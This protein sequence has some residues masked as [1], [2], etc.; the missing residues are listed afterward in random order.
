MQTDIGSAMLR[1]FAIIRESLSEAQLV[2][3]IASGALERLFTEALTEQVLHRAFFPVREKIRTST[4][5]SF[6]YTVRELPKSGRVDGQIAVAFDHLDPVV[7][8]GIRTLE[9]KVVATL[10][11]DTRETVR[12]F[13][14]NGLRDG[15][16]PVV[17]AKDIRGVVGLAPNQERAVA[18]FRASLEGTSGTSPLSY[19]LRDKRFD[20]SVK[21]G[22]LT[23]EQI[24]RMTEAYQKKM[25]AHHAE[26]VART[27]AIDA[28]K[29]GQRLAWEDSIKKGVVDRDKLYKRWVGV[30][31]D[32][33][34]PSHKKMEG[35]TV[36]FDQPFSNGQMIP[37]D[38][39]WNCRCI[40]RYTIGRPA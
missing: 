33:E 13:V 40:A 22:E 16:N 18:N 29:L 25:T 26:T 2:R 30:M 28:Q 3:I 1:A 21:K 23:P 7:I 34:R 4:Y 11:G 37:G 38:G 6:R 36:H 12:A 39:E 32:R 27:A 15:K 19:K 31:D 24:D 9:T 14:E 35:N 10:Q 5:Q 17:I 8:K 20:K